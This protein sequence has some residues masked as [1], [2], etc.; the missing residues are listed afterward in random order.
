MQLK[1]FIKDYDKENDILFVHW[2]LKPTDSSIECKTEEGHKFVS[3][4]NPS[5]SS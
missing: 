2:G 4:S 1:E 5:C 3:L